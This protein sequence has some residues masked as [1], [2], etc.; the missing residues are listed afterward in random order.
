[1]IVLHDEN[2]RS[3]EK[4]TG[5]IVYLNYSKIYGI[6]C[7]FIDD[8]LEQISYVKDEDTT[9]GRFTIQETYSILSIHAPEE[10]WDNSYSDDID[11]LSL[12]WVGPVLFINSTANL[13]A[14][15]S[16]RKGTAVLFKEQTLLITTEKGK[17][18]EK[19]VIAL[20]RKLAEQKKARQQE[21]KEQLEE[22]KQTKALEELKSL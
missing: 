16:M 13:T 4:F 12:N 17:S 20:E 3:N 18:F 5:T 1:M 15:L 11:R 19:V 2:Y 7:N 21:L 14:A 9:S 22:Q 6:F 8:K 10:T